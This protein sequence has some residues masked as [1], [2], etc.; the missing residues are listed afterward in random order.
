MSLVDWQNNG[1]LRP[2]QSSS[3]EIDGLFSIIDRDLLDSTTVDLSNDWK[4]GIAYNAALKLCMVLLHA[5]GYRPEKNLQHFRTIASLPLILGPTKSDDS[6]YLETCR[7]KRNTVE[8]DLA[9]VASESEA[10]ELL[11]F[12][13]ELRTEVLIWLGNTYPSLVPYGLK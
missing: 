5:S 6:I 11:G 12:A 2:H 9:G 8:Y 10:T 13:C 1:W 3:K 7:V 4:F